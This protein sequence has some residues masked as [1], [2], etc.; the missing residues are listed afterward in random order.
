[1][2][3]INYTKAK[4]IY[5]NVLA[6]GKFHQEVPEG[7][8]GAVRRDYKTTDGKQGS[9]NELLIDDISGII[10]EV[11]KFEG[12]FGTNVIVIFEADEGDAPIV[13]SLSANSNF[14]EDFLKKLNS[15][16]TD[17][18]VTLLPFSFE[19]K[20]DGK[21]KRGITI[22]KGDTLIYKDKKIINEKIQNYYSEKKGDKWVPAHGYPI[23]P[24]KA[25]KKVIS[26]EEWKIYFAQARVFMLEKLEDHP[27]YKDQ[28]E[29]K[30]KEKVE[31]ENAF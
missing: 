30:S 7:T 13:V 1:M 29:I 25:G 16:D 23:A 20:E 9:K 24:K 8:E 27:L 12:D 18:E 26:K 28:T 2:A 22:Y 14:G 4:P 3:K 21:T 6:D 19:N 31:E 15:I 5:L 17:E 10:S 11:S